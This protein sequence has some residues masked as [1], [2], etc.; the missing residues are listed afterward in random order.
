[1]TGYVIKAFVLPPGVNLFGVLI[2]TLF[3]QHSNRLRRVVVWGSIATLWIWSVPFAAAWLA[4][5]LERYDPLDPASIG[6]A[7]AIVV[8]AAGTYKDAREYGGVDTVAHDTLERLRYGVKLARDLKLPLAVTG[9]TVFANAGEPAAVLMAR[10]LAEEFHIPARWIE[11]KSRNTAENA[12]KLRSLLPLRDI[13]LVTHALHMARA[14]GVFEGVGFAVTPAP[15]GFIVGE[16]I[17]FGLFDWLPSISALSTSRAVLHEW[18]GIAYY[19]LR[20]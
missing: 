8:L 10:V 3:M 14:V 17:S 16:E 5:S 7:Q 4:Q 12:S 13:I 15:M 6:D 20:Y 11:D 19:R 18:M 2:G 9:G 1:M